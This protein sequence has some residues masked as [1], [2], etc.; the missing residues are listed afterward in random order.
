MKTIKIV[1]LAVLV[2]VV[3]FVACQKDEEAMN[4]NLEVSKVERPYNAL[5][6]KEMIDM[7]EHYDKTRKPVLEDA[8]GY[9]DTRINFY[10]IE[11]LENY[12]AYV[13]QLSKEKGI[14]LTGINFVSGSYP[15]NTSHGKPGY[16]NI[17]LMPTTS[18]N[19]KNIAFDPVHSQENKVKTMK[20]MFATYGYNWVYDS[21]EDYNNRFVTNSKLQK[22]YAKRIQTSDI[23]SSGANWGNATPPYDD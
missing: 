11:T 4:Q 3:T 13:K 10:S 14:E 9:E 8:L 2:S 17:M 12:I 19:G 5:M 22:S 18:I 15:E 20:E 21:K 7:L 16:Q 1:K 6:Y 23:E